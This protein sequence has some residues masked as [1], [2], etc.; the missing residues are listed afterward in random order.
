MTLIINNYLT[1]TFQRSISWEWHRNKWLKALRSLIYAQFITR[2]LYLIILEIN[3]R[4]QITIFWFVL[5]ISDCF[6]W[7]ISY[8]FKIFI[9]FKWTRVQ[10]IPSFICTKGIIRHMLENHD[11]HVYKEFRC[12]HIE[13]I[14]FSPMLI[15]LK[16]LFLCTLFI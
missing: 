12:H 4:K 13:E 15:F 9:N 1:F 16:Y 5:F 11:T 7:A 10:N 8:L 3:Y 6:F 14:D 2:Q